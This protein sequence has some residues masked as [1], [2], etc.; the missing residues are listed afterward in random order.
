[1]VGNRSTSSLDEIVERRR[2][3]VDGSRIDREGRIAF[4]RAVEID[5]QAAAIVRKVAMRGRKADGIDRKSDRCLRFVD[6]PAL[7]RRRS[8]RLNAAQKDRQTKNAE[9]ARDCTAIHDHAVKSRRAH[10]LIPQVCFDPGAGL[11]HVKHENRNLSPGSSPDARP[12][13]VARP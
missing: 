10:E 9:P 11:R 12:L 3:D 5:Q 13:P 2:A 1:M 6:A 8:L 7:C 4:R